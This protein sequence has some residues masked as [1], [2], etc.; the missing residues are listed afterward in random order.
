V[1]FWPLT[2]SIF[3]V[4]NGVRFEA[5]FV[6]VGLQAANAKTMQSIEPRNVSFMSSPC[7]SFGVGTT[8]ATQMNEELAGV[9]GVIWDAV[10]KP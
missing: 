8:I 6:F 5:D 4:V 3:F 7:K 2:G 10:T 1:A 9:K